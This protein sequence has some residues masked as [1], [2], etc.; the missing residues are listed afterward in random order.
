MS[1]PGGGRKKGGRIWLLT[2]FVLLMLL[3]LGYGGYWMVA[4]SRLETEIDARADAMRRAGYTVEMEGRR[5]DGFPFRLRLTLPNVRIAS[6]AGW[7]LGAPSFEAQAY[8]HDP[9]HWVFLA[10]QGLTINRP[11]GGG[12]TVKGEALRASLVGLGGPN[13]RGAA[14]GVKLAF[15]PAT[16]AAPF[17]LAAAE[18]M[19]LNIKPGDAD[20]VMMLIRLQGGKAGAGALLQRMAADAPV[21]G[22]LD[23]KATKA[24]AFQG[25]SFGEAAK[26]WSTA[27][28][29]VEIVRTE[30]QG[31]TVAAWAKGGVL[32][33]GRDG[34]LQGS[35]PLEMRQAA[36]SLGA[37][38]GQPLD[39]NTART[40]ASIAAA[41]DQGGSATLNLV[42]QAGVTTLGPVPIGPAPKVF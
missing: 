28:G 22:L 5:L 4:K 14:E 3:T 15:A 31:G 19:D 16:G 7:S 13:W 2:P 17:S 11:K 38:A 39:P 32:T 29:Q 9:G 36:K 25:A 18:R 37:L 24:A 10:P 42:F 41:R 1:D 12:L 35:I 27:G 34:R 40:A 21:T 20:Q 33:A 23:L 26:A 8:L 30:L 6:P